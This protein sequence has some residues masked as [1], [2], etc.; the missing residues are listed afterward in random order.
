MRGGVW[1]RPGAAPAP[2]VNANM[3]QLMRGLFFPTS[4]VIFAA[5]ADLGV[6]VRDSQPSTSPNPLT[7][8][9]EPWQAVEYAALML[10]ESASLLLLPGRECANGRQAPVERA[11]WVQFSEQI[12]QAGLAAYK[13]AQSRQADAMVEA[14]GAVSEACAACHGVYRSERAGVENRCAS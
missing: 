3:L 13:A 1:Q 5:Q 2:R 6:W 11:D 9:Y 4:N 7:G 10:T 14:S 12:R 8:L